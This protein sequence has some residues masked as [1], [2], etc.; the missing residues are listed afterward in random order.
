MADGP[1]G[2]RKQEDAADML[3][4]NRSVPA[5]SFPTAV[6]SACSW[7]RE[8]LRQEGEAIAGEALA[9]GVGVVLEYAL[10]YPDGGG[11]HHDKTVLQGFGY[12]PAYGNP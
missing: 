2:L 7:D 1:H 11:Q 8:L 5:T 4:L 6:S 3:G 10:W 9:N 12:R